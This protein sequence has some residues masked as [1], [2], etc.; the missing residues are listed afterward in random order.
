MKFN[1][2]GNFKQTNMAKTEKIEVFKYDPQVFPIRLHVVFSSNLQCVLGRYDGS[3]GSDFRDGSWD[4][5][6]TAYTYSG[7]VECETR[8]VVILVVFRSKKHAGPGTVAHEAKHAADRIFDYIG[9]DNTRHESH[10]Y[11]VEWVVNC[12]NNALKNKVE[13]KWGIWRIF[14]DVLRLVKRCVL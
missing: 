13:C 7:I 9:E 10:A 5:G 11:L 3:D 4:K 14:D 12:V 6:A 2:S 8:L 1:L